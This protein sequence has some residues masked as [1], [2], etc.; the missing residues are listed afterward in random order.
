[1]SARV[2][3]LAEAREAREAAKRASFER[4]HGL[5]DAEYERLAAILAEH[6]FAAKAER[7]LVFERDGSLCVRD[8][9][10]G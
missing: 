3:N 10:D 5:N 6:Y 4:R 2:M 8:D 7:G 1:M 9:S